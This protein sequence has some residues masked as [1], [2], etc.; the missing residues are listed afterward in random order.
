M[1]KLTLEHVEAVS[2]AK[3]NLHR[4]LERDTAPR[5]RAL[6]EKQIELMNEV[7]WF[8]LHEIFNPGLPFIADNFESDLKKLHKDHSHGPETE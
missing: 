3:L 2:A 8:V 4:L 7:Y 5:W 6:I 1:K